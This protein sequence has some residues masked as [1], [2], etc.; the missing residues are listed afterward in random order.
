MANV[1]HMY[2]GRLRGDGE[3]YPLIACEKL[4]D[5]DRKGSTLG[6]YGASARQGREGTESFLEVS[7]PPVGGRR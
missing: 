1:E 3:E 5:G 7:Q 2:R 6:S 4:S